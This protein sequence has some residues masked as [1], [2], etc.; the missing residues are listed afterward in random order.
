MS[1][2][3]KTVSKMTASEK[4]VAKKL[5]VFTFIVILMC[6]ASAVGACAIVD[7]RLAMY[8]G[9]AIGLIAGIYSSSVWLNCNNE[10]K[11]PSVQDAFIVGMLDAIAAFVVGLGFKALVWLAVVL[12]I[13][14]W[15]IKV[16][17]ILIENKLAIGMI[18]AGIAFTFTLSK[19]LL[20]HRKFISYDKFE[21]FVRVYDNKN[22]DDEE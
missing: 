10:K 19:L 18:V 2:S 13:N 6:I 1:D 8:G 20:H 12:K 22:K 17:N 9:V 3:N 4:A 7:Y 16:Y 14:T 21:Q 5:S 11:I 15:F